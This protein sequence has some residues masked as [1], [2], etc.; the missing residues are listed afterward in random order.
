MHECPWVAVEDVCHMYGMTYATAKNRIGLKT[1]PV[2][3]Y[4]EGKKW[5]IDKE[6]H[7]TYFRLKRERGLHALMST[8]GTRATQ[9]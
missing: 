8:N 3:V 2:E 1:F 7:E 6:V 5:V 9:P 4:K